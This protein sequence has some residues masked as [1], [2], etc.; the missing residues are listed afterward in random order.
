MGGCGGG[1]FRTRWR[2]P[3]VLETIKEAFKAWLAVGSA[4]AANR[5]CLTRRAAATK[6]RCGS[7]SERPQGRIFGW[8]QRNS[9][10]PSDGSRKGGRPQPSWC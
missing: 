1:D 4:E 3:E 5:S 2:T 10:K 9:G 7:S 8:P 6:L